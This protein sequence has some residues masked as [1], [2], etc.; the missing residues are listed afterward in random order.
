MWFRLPAKTRIEPFFMLTNAYVIHKKH[1]MKTVFSIH[2]ARGKHHHFLLK[3]NRQKT[4]KSEPIAIKKVKKRSKKCSMWW[5]LSKKKAFNLQY[6][7]IQYPWCP[8]S[9]KSCMLICTYVCLYC[10]YHCL[11]TQG[12]T[13]NVKITYKSTNTYLRNETCE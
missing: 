3:R 2:F 10:L 12:K 4:L 8:W 5:T 9:Q 6:L 11:D 13:I 1:F 7:P